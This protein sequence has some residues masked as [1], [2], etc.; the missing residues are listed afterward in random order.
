MGVVNFYTKNHLSP[1]SIL[2]NMMYSTTS[3]DKGGY[4]RL[5]EK[6]NYLFHT[7]PN[8]AYKVSAVSQFMHNS[9]KPHMVKRTLRYL[10]SAPSRN[11]VTWMCGKLV[12]ARSSAANVYR[13]KL[14]AGIITFPFVKSK[15]QL[16][17]VLAK[18]ARCLASLLS[19][20]VRVIS[21]HQLERCWNNSIV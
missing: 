17:N 12:V 5:V 18:P 8:I 7:E 6:L 21:I 2:R 15:S 10:K 4:Q 1:V 19:S 9:R 20:W 13:E 3:I 11:P 14:E 16:G